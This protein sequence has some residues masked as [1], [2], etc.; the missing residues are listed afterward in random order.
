M[1]GFLTSTAFCESGDTVLG[2]GFIM[3]TG[4]PNNVEP[5]I[6]QPTTTDNGWMVQAN[7]G[8]TITAVAFCFDNSPPNPP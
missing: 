2:G 6:S 1:R 4:T 8:N 7:P 3:N 5:R